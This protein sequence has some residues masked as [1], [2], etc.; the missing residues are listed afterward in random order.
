[1]KEACI[2]KIQEVVG[3]FQTVC[4]IF[5]AKVKLIGSDAKLLPT[6]WLRIIRIQRGL[7]MLLLRLERDFRYDAYM[8]IERQVRNENENRRG[9]RD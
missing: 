4:P 6:R 9:N 3:G 1:M 5:V 7:L 8:I 2:E